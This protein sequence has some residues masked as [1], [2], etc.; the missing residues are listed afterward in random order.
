MR[1]KPNTLPTRCPVCDHK[2]GSR[3][4]IRIHNELASKTGCRKYP[5]PK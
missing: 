5:E 1:L 2:G 4:A 3:E